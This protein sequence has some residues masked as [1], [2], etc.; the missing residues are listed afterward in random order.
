M[1]FG[2]Y[3]GLW[4][5]KILEETKSEHIF[6]MVSD[7]GYDDIE[8]PLNEPE[9][10]NIQLVKKLSKKFNIDVTTSVALPI[11]ANFM[12]VNEEEREYAR[13]FMKNCIQKAS[14][15]GSSVLGGV[16]YAPWGK[17]DISKT[18]T[19]FDFLIDGLRDV[20]KYA[21]NL[22]VKLCV[23]PVNRFESN[24]INTA[25]EGLSLI[26]KIGSDNIFLLLDT[27]HMNIE[28]KNII[29]T[30]KQVNKKVGHFHTCEND[31]GIPG[32]GH[33]PWEKVVNA[34]KDINYEGYLVFEAFKASET[35][36]SASIWRADELT[37]D[38]FNSAKE[39]LSF[40]KSLI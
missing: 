14:L 18:P 19:S 23:E 24:V 7:I 1:K 39:S 36:K 5:S 26:E 2:V 16:I 21:K 38:A 33:V 25:S 40:L 22:N 20:D 6:K 34:L 9:N 12:S 3:L 4:E 37:P 35:L 28:E 10:I 31:R 13:S 17:T 30:I 15:M 27:F 29:S 32:T 8:L 11:N